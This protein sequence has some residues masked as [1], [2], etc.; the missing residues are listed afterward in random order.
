M[1]KFKIINTNLQLT[2]AQDYA[3]IN[4]NFIT[5]LVNVSSGQY[6][7]TLSYITEYTAATSRLSQASS[8]LFVTLQNIVN[9]TNVQ[10]FLSNVQEHLNANV[11]QLT[12]KYS[13]TN[14]RN[15][16]VYYYQ[17]F[18]T[19]LSTNN[20]TQSEILSMNILYLNNI[21]KANA[22]ACISKYND[23]HFKI[24]LEAATNFMQLME[25]ETSTTGAQLEVL[26]KEINDMVVSIVK[27]VEKI[28]ANKETARVEFDNFVGNSK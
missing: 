25:G 24:Y 1:L 9:I 12:L 27:S 3:T 8:F 18:F 28:I 20:G 2:N 7:R 5:S 19:N 10:S 11:Q 26:R 13:P 16:I 17:T 21:L 22:T 6:Q 4:V 14:V 15:F 23:D